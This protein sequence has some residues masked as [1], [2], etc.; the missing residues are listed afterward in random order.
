MSAR[1]E[2]REISL[3]R[4]QLNLSNPRHKEAGTRDEAMVKLLL[5]EQI[6]ELARDIAELGGINPMER[7]GVFPLEGVG[8]GEEQFYAAAEGNR[9]LCA[10]ILLDDPEAVPA[11][12][13]NRARYVRAFKKMSQQIDPITQVPCVLFDDMDAARPWLERLHNG[14]RDGTGRRRWTP[15]QQARNTSDRT[16]RAATQ[17]RDLAIKLGLV[18]SDQLARTTTTQ[19][20]F[21]SNARFRRAMGLERLEDGSLERTRCW[22]DFSLMLHKFMTDIANGAINSRSHNSSREIEAYAQQL[23]ALDGLELRNVRQGELDQRNDE[24][25]ADAA[26]E[27]DDPVQEANQPEEVGGDAAVPGAKDKLQL[28]RPTRNTIGKDD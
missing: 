2:P 11:E 16:N 24:I 1:G 28:S 25:H 19:Q 15:E 3:E 8:N 6:V 18:T 21:I 23:E 27:T 26:G 9:R 20:R 14:A 13:P 12:M 5:H 17:L 10:L 7:L 4:L 22:A